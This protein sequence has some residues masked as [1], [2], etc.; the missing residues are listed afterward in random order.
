MQEFVLQRSN[1]L[2]AQDLKSF[3]SLLIYV[4]LLLD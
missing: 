4:I 2:L 1:I 3:K